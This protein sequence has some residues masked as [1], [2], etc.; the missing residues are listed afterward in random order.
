MFNDNASDCV[1]LNNI[2]PQTSTASNDDQNRITLNKHV[3]YYHVHPY[4]NHKDPVISSFSSNVP[5][6]SCFPSDLG[7]LAETLVYTLWAATTLIYWRF[8]YDALKNV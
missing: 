6:I 8:N 5:E 1:S 7:V 2:D 3:E 4:I